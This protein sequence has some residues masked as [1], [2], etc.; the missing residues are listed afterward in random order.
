MFTKLTSHNKRQKDKIIRC[1]FVNQWCDLKCVEIK[2][3]WYALNEHA[4]G[5]FFGYIFDASSPAQGRF[6]PWNVG[7]SIHCITVHGVT[8]LRLCLIVKKHR[9]CLCISSSVSNNRLQGTATEYSSTAKPTIEIFMRRRTAPPKQG[10][11]SVH[12]HSTQ[13]GPFPLSISHNYERGCLF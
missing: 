7:F 11:I 12:L 8:N 3:L 9:H 4:M 5:F 6:S 1:A 13:I 2:I 10:V